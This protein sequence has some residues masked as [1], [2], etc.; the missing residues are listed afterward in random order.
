VSS[1]FEYRITGFVMLLVIPFYWCCDWFCIVYCCWS[2][3]R[4]Y[5]TYV[6]SL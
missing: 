6:G 3:S 5:E 1:L 2:Y 4:W